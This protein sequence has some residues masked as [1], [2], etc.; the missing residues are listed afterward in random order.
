MEE[1]KSLLFELLSFYDPIAISI[2]YLDSKQH[3][4]RSHLSTDE[5]TG[6]ESMEDRI[7][8]IDEVEVTINNYTDPIKYYYQL[9]TYKSKLISILWQLQDSLKM[10]SFQ[11]LVSF[12]LALLINHKN[13]FIIEEVEEIAEIFSYVSP[14]SP[15]KLTQWELIFNKKEGLI[16]IDTEKRS[17]VSA[18]TNERKQISVY[19][20]FMIEIIEEL[21]S[22][23]ENIQTIKID[24]RIA[25]SFELTNPHQSLTDFKKSLITKGYI[26][27][28][29]IKYFN[30]VFSGGPIEKKINWIDGREAFKFFI[31]SL[32]REGYIKKVWEKWKIVEKCFLLNGEEIDGGKIATQQRA[33]AS[34]QRSIYNCL[35]NLQKGKTQKSNI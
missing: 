12:S 15:K 26:E 30:N 11:S 32:I 27:D 9:A 1:Y 34:V 22:L 6:K 29:S 21:I 18:G 33:N 23:M 20:Y 16:Y 17:D 7:D 3:I 14:D 28:I 19:Y 35:A 31:D 5:D 2:R 25:N 4:Q 13:N 8:I 24:K 10:T